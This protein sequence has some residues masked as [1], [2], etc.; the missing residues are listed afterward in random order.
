[1]IVSE[2]EPLPR[3]PNKGRSGC[4]TKI[5]RRR[6]LGTAWWAMAAIC[7]LTLL[8]LVPI[9]SALFAPTADV[10][11]HVGP[12]LPGLTL[13]T[14]VLVLGVALGTGFIGTGLAWLTSVCE[15]PGRRFFAWALMLPLAIPA[16][17]FGFVVVGLFDFSGPVASTWREWFGDRAW[18]PP[19]RSVGGVVLTLSFSL[20][21]Y[22]Y[23]LARN[24]FL[25]Q[26]GRALEA[27]RSLGETALGGFFRI[28]L[29]MA[30]PWIGAGVMLVVMETLA[31]F[32]AVSVFNYDTFTTAIYKAWFGLFSLPAA[33]QL[34]SFLMVFALLALTVEQQQ[35]ARQ[36]YTL[37]ARS[38]NGT[39]PIRLHGPLRWCA[40]GCAGLV[41]LL[42]FI[43]PLIQ[44]V[45]WSV[46]VLATDWDERFSDYLLN[47]GLMAGSGALL[48]TL[49]SLV[50][51]WVK[52]RHTDWKTALMVRL[53]TLGYSLPGTVLAVGIF[54]PF[55]WLDNRLIDGARVLFDA[56]LAPI[57]GGGLAALLLAYLIR[58]L[59][60]GF[61]ATDSALQRITPA[62]EEA[63]RSMG[64]SGFAMIRRVHLPLLRGGL[65]SAFLL[66]FVDIMKEMPITLLMRP[67]GWDSLAVRIFEMTSEGEWQR[68]ALPA[69]VLVLAGLVPIL[70]LVGASEK[71][72]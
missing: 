55:A 63:S 8:P 32:G 72:H 19:I 45:I 21:P 68:A 67:F 49:G 51:S 31:D 22:V 29:P 30:R 58:F 65:F 24:A 17:V 12:L 42:A 53:A 41:L 27:A 26:S 54:I 5:H 47:T 11:A 28:A 14:L 56:E 9:A 6:T 7:A 39:R 37:S 10:W 46:G 40:A 18:F 57:L 23:L 38:G 69:V 61:G 20:Y 44:L 16:Y 35:R 50:L 52:R 33:A 71:R 1:V 3:A 34:A 15:F 48:I 66:A 70:L 13:N 36:R 60:V 2:T 25:T 4:S 59:A 43:M 64:V 62:M